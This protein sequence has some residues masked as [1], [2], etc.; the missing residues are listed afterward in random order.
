MTTAFLNLTPPY[1]TQRNWH[2]VD[3]CLCVCVQTCRSI[4]IN[5]ELLGFW[6]CPLSVILKKG[7]FGN[8]DFFFSCARVRGWVTPTLLRP[9]E[10]AT[11]NH[12][13]YS[14]SVTLCSLE[15]WTMGKVQKK[16]KIKPE[17]YTPSSESIPS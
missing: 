11:L 8:L 13:T 9:L 1:A 16:K 2:V 6:T 4:L 3:S 7:R 17:C 5:A 12:W 14:V 15:Y 10:R